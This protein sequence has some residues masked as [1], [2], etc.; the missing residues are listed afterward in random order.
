MEI[1]KG[2]ITLQ[3]DNNAGN[4]R[5]TVTATVNEA[6]D[7]SETF[8][9]TASDCDDVAVVINREGLRETYNCSDGDFILSD[10]STFNVK[11]ERYKDV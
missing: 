8:T 3:Y 6:I 5:V 11:K 9:F 10:S 4:Q 7:Y 1:I 2:G